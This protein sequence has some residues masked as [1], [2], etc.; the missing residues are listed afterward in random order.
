LIRIADRGSRIPEDVLSEIF[1]FGFT[2][3]A[4][5][6][7]IGLRIGLPTCKR[8]IDEIGGRIW[9]DSTVGA[10]TTVHIRLPT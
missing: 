1:E 7:R 5:G 4:T 2:K 8:T 9:I 10:G 6:E 3:K